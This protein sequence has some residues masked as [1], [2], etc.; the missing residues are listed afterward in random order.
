MFWKTA[1][2]AYAGVTADDPDI[3]RYLEISADLQQSGNEGIVGR[4]HDIG[5]RW[6]AERSRDGRTLEI[7]FGSG[8]HRKFVRPGADYF[9][10]EFSSWHFGSEAWRA[11]R[12]RGVGADARALPYRDAAFDSVISIYNLEHIDDLQGVFR[13][14]RRVLKPGGRFLIALPCEGGLLWN[15]GRELTTR[16]VFQKKYGINYDKAIAF[17]HVRDFRGV[18]A[19]L[20]RSG[21]FRIEP[22]RLFPMLVPTHHFNLIGCVTARKT[23]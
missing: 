6:I 17:E 18:L 12:T 23:E 16:R 2:A 4:I 15:L 14:V 11:I 10:S 19:E 20:R 13:E 22:L 21:L 1:R 9:P 5:H 8:Y 7:G 3:Q